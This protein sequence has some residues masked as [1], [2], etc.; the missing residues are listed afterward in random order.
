MIEDRKWRIENDERKHVEN[1][2][3]KDVG[4]KFLGKV[5]FGV[6]TGGTG[7]EDRR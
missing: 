3:L 5:T 2:E 4:L 1:I 7:I 6:E